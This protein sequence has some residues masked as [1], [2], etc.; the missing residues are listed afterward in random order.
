MRLKIVRT[1]GN[2][3]YAQKRATSRAMVVSRPKFSSWP[4]SGTSPRNYGWLF[5]LLHTYRHFGG[6]NWLHLHGRSVSWAS[7]WSK[8]ASRILC[9]SY[10]STWRESVHSSRAWVTSARL[11][12]VIFQTIVALP[13]K[14]K[15]ALQL[16]VRT[17]KT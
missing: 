6:M 1:A 16:S 4:D 14:T 11:H 5:V 7:R 8:Q 2:G 10:T 17:P 12:D 3:I 13:I 9:E 15:L